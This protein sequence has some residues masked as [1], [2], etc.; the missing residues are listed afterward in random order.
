VHL[1][2]AFHPLTGQAAQKAA[3]LKEGGFGESV[4]TPD[5]PNFTSY[6]HILISRKNSRPSR[7][8]ALDRT[9]HY[10]PRPTA[11]GIF[12][13][14]PR[15]IAFALRRW[16][17]LESV[18]FLRRGRVPTRDDD[19]VFGGIGPV[20]APEACFS[21]RSRRTDGHRDGGRS[22]AG[23]AA[24]W[25]ATAL[26][27]GVAELREFRINVAELSAQRAHLKRFQATNLRLKAIRTPT[28]DMSGR[29]LGRLLSH[30]T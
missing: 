22:P 23:A 2:D 28:V 11:R 20:C 29:R 7:F 25:S 14:N 9:G 30:G 8:K 27:L 6:R 21:I 18:K 5:P 24:E 12:I 16:L 17:R 13:K 10:Q 1:R 15:R 3:A 19:R 4:V 26:A